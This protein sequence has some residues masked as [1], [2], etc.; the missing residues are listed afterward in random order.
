MS[1]DV[2]IVD[3]KV[4]SLSNRRLMVLL[5][6]QA[7]HR[8]ECI[9]ARCVVRSR[10]WKNNRFRRSKTTITDGL[11]IG[12]N[13]RADDKEALHSNRPISS[14]A[15]TALRVVEELLVGS[16]IEAMLPLIRQRLTA[17]CLKTHIR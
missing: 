13:P 2:C 16:Q 7:V 12:S 15:V 5:M 14:P 10:T 6:Y 17:L 4:W 9:K 1:L 3:G 8:D 11:S